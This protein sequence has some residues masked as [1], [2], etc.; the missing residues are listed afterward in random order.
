MKT[1]HFLFL[2]WLILPGVALAQLRAHFFACPARIRE[3]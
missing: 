3:S 2:V 1:T